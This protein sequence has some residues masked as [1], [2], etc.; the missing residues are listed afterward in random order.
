MEI[1][2]FEDIEV[3]VE[4]ERGTLPLNRPERLNALSP[5]TLRRLADAAAWF[6]EQPGL[7]VV[8]VAGRGRSTR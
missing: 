3:G 8:V 6:G 4:G 5:A 1:P 7:K 2:E